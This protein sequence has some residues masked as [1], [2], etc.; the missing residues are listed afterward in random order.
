VGGI[1]RRGMTTKDLIATITGVLILFGILFGSYQYFE[2]RYALAEEVKKIEKRIDY[3]ILSDQLQ[4]IQE[5]IW[6][7]QDRAQQKKTVDETTKEELRSL[8]IKKQETQKKLD[9]LE[10]EK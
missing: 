7:I 10:K 9:S 5:R 4:M 6:K 8:E 1:G 3:K 2:K